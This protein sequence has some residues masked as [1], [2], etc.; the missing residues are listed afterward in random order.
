MTYALLF[1]LCVIFVE[2]FL[3]LDLRRQAAAILRQARQS[4]SVLTDRDVGDDEKEAFVRSAALGVLGTTGG[5]AAKLALIAGVLYAAYRGAAWAFP[6]L[7]D[8]LLRDAVS[9]VVVVTVTLT[10]VCYAWARDAVVKQL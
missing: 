6:G 8:A 9:P 7:E 3:F 10:A 4:V 1:G 5:F 2:L